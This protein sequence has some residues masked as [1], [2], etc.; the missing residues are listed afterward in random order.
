MRTFACCLAIGL[1]LLCLM[2][3]CSRDAEIVTEMEQRIS[4]RAALLEATQ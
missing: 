2:V 3:W 1:G 4:H